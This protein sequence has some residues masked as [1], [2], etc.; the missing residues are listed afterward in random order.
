MSNENRKTTWTESQSFA[1]NVFELFTDKNSFI[2]K[3]IHNDLEGISWVKN[4][5]SMQNM[6]SLI[7]TRRIQKSSKTSSSNMTSFIFVSDVE[8]KLFWNL[9][10][11]VSY[12]KSLDK[13]ITLIFWY[14]RCDFRSLIELHMKIDLLINKINWNMMYST[15]LRIA[16][17]LMIQIRIKI[18]IR[19]NESHD[20]SY[21]DSVSRLTT[22]IFDDHRRKM[23]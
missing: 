3:M 2:T 18:I 22:S 15:R 1:D 5:T 11:I 8:T 16:L 12:S 13:F 23:K 21:S 4:K 14:W 10:E 17:H 9:N 19:K 7:T 20:M 6:D